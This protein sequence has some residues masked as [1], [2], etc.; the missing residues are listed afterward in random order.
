MS[1]KGKALIVG[2]LMIIVF[3]IAFVSAGFFPYE[4][5]KTTVVPLLIKE[6]YTFAEKTPDK[7]LLFHQI[8]SKNSF[9]EFARNRDLVFFKREGMWLRYY[10][11]V[12]G[13]QFT[14]SEKAGDDLRYTISKA[15]VQQDGVLITLERKMVLLI[16]LQI[17][18]PLFLIAVCLWLV[19]CVWTGNKAARLL[20]YR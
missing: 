8:V 2:L 4:A 14:Y 1:R 9:I 13:D 3:D 7:P 15:E 5:V 19:Y 17:M 11:N 20:F 12:N 6:G 18:M 10:L 16:V